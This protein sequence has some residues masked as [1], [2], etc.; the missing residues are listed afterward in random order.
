MEKTFPIFDLGIDHFFP[1]EPE[2]RTQK[3]KEEQQR[4]A[5]IDANKLDD[6]VEGAHSDKAGKFMLLS[7]AIKRSDIHLEVPF[8]QNRSS[9]DYFFCFHCTVG[10][11]P[12][13]LEGFKADIAFIFKTLA[14]SLAI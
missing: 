2:E 5:C 13:D 4:L 8:L 14:C 9:F 1:T 7:R 3:K 12:K 6:L 11:S 10:I